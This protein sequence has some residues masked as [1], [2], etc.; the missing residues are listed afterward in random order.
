MVTNLVVR[1]LASA[2]VAISL[3]F[4]LAPSA[5]ADPD[6]HIPNGAAGWCVG[7]HPNDGLEQC[8][9]EAFPDGTFFS[10]LRGIIAS[11]PF[12]G[13]QWQSWASCMTWIDGRVQGSPTGCGGV[14][15]INL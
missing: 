4:T 9:G 8:L 14:P 2:A 3:G 5:L 15:S 13:P 1:G 6:P 10:Q 12:R 11:Q 7:G